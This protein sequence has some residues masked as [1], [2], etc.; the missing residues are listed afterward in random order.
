MA[1]AG[2]MRVDWW[3][4]TLHLYTGLFLTPWMAV[5]ATSAL[6]LNHDTWLGQKFGVPLQSWKVVREMPLTVDAAFPSQ[7]AEQARAVLQSLDLDGQHRIL[8]DSNDTQLTI[9]RACPGGD[10]RITWRRDQAKAVVQRQLP[11]SGLRLLHGLHF[12]RGYD[13]RYPTSVAW[14]FSVDCVVASTWFWLL[15]G[16][17]IWARRPKKRILGGV[18]LGGG[19]LLFV[20][21]VWLLCR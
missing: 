16:I 13:W 3:M 7:R 2:W 19:C 8:G 18:F 5:Y 21:L 11:F 9:Y 14:A 1:T 17:Y 20:G 10:Y 4:R 15:S 12:G 6:L